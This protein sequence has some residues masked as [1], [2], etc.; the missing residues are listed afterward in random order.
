MCSKGDNP[1]LRSQTFEVLILSYAGDLFVKSQGGLI[2]TT[3]I[4]FRYEQKVSRQTQKTV[5]KNLSQ[6]ERKI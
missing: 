4:C 5:F 2:E 3:Y 6:T 1:K